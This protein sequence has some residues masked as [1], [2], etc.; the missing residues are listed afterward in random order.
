MG[1]IREIHLSYQN[2]PD[3]LFQS[4]LKNNSEIKTKYTSSRLFTSKVHQFENL[5]E[6]KNAT[7]GIFINYLFLH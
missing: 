1:K 4:K 2:M 5:P 7:E 3:E 6:Q